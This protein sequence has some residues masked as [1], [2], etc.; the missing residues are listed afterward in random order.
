M[1]DK[2]WDRCNDAVRRGQMIERMALELE[3]YDPDVICL[4]EVPSEATAAR[5]AKRLGMHYAHFK[6]G[7]K[8]KGWPEGISGAVLSRYPILD[9]KAHPSLNWTERPEK[10]FTRFWGRVVLDTPVG[11]LA[12]HGMHG[13]IYGSDSRLAEIAE[14][15]P[16]IK[17]DV[18]AGMSVILLGD[19]NYTPDSPEYA[20]T[21]AAGL[22]DSFGGPSNEPALWTIPSTKRE[23]RIDYI[24]S[25]GPISKRLV[26]AK[27]LFEGA[28]R[29][30]PDDA[31]SF[32]LSDHVPVLAV[33]SAR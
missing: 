28:F 5:L 18:A 24:W 19:L 12:V 11:K 17:N 26:S 4:E 15:L 14:V 30:N 16:V 1:A 6:G 33:F 10:L 22:R 7:W 9:A 29:T 32:A 31:N 25:A 2:H 20:K 21:A 27:V 3:L 23:E 13:S 8:S